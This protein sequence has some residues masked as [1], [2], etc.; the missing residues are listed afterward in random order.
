[1]GSCNVPFNTAWPYE[2]FRETWTSWETLAVFL[3]EIVLEGIGGSREW[4]LRRC[5]SSS[6]NRGFAEDGNIW[7]VRLLVS[8]EERTEPLSLDS[9]GVP[10]NV[11]LGD[12]TL[13][14]RSIDCL[15]FLGE[16]R[17]SFLEQNK[18]ATQWC[19][20]TK[21]LE[22]LADKMKRKTFSVTNSLFPKQWL[23]VLA[24]KQIHED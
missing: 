10:R 1:M 17:R 12:G 5:C 7:G 23:K 2:L 21:A 11:M 24:S 14:Y 8:D 16:R 9:V 6:S 18:E 22:I 20:K 15:K 13:L 4:E 3:T 19:E